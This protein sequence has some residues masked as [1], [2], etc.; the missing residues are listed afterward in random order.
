MKRL[1]FLLTLCLL[2]A[3]AAPAAAEEPFRLESAA[4]GCSLTVPGLSGGDVTAELSGTSAVF[5]H[6]PS[7]EA[8]SGLIGTLVAVAPRSAVFSAPYTDQSYRIV[9][10]GRDRVFLWKSPGG[11]INSNGA[12]T[13]GFVRAASA[14]SVENLRRYLRPAEPDDLP[15]LNT[16]RHLAYLAAQDGLLRPDE[17]LTRG[18]LAE[19][20]YALLEADNKREL[21]EGPFRD[22]A[23]SSRSQAVSYL[24]SYG[25][26]S[27]YADGTFRPDA[28]VT[29][30][31]LAVLLH[32]CQFAVPV[33]VYGD[34]EGFSD[35]PEGYWAAD[36]ISSA[37]VLGWMQGGADRLFHPEEPVTRAQAATAI[38]RMLGRDE[39]HTA[40]GA[41]LSPFSDVTSG[42]WAYENLLEATGVLTDDTTAPFAPADGVLPES[43]SASAFLS[44]TEGWAV[45]GG[46]LLRT[47]DGGAAW[48]P[49]GR[50]LSVSVSG[51]Y[52]FSSQSGVLLGGGGETPLVL[53]ETGDGGVTW[54]DLLADPDVLAACLPLEQ[55]G[56]EKAVRSAILSAE[57]RPAGKDAAYLLVRYHPYDSIYTLDLTAIRQ[58]ALISSGS[59]GTLTV[60]PLR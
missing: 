3:L 16:R 25:I 17:P 59:S 42:H 24:A 57:L 31:Q 40:V 13:D 27:G 47:V 6:T 29:R 20:L 34:A 44:E 37:G 49:V 46:Q 28:P 12:H 38:N 19:M 14:L 56:S 15:V 36:Y 33:G 10:M 41:G 18:Q 30:A 23:G 55:F 50:P 8:G 60:E 11:G 52:F 5:Y 7:R 48:T 9:A 58:T 53:L 21:Y 2:F 26:L 39:S 1:S 51:L 45:S 43:T 4:L 35:V 32:R 22:T 54:R